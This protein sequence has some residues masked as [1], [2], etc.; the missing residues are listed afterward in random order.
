MGVMPDGRTLEA[1]NLPVVWAAEAR[2]AAGDPVPNGNTSIQDPRTKHF[3]TTIQGAGVAE[4]PDRYTAEDEDVPYMT[5]EEL[6]LIVADYEHSIGNPAGAIAQVNLI[7]AGRGISAI[8]GAWQT[9]LLGSDDET[10]FM[11]LEER[12]RE[13]YV[14]GGRFWSTKIQNTDLLWFPR[15]Q[16]VTSNGFYQWAG[17]VRQHM[18]NDEFDRN[19]NFIALGGRDAR[20]TGCGPS[21]RPL[22]T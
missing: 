7:R 4:V 12:R 19:P 10:R 14:E 16:G 2:N 22:P 9:T 20:G 17:G 3:E 5:W 1:G 15:R 11:L 8:S 21:Q 6:R 18:P 13:F